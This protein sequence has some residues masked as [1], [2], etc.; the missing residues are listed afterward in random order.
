MKLRRKQI[1]APGGKKFVIRQS[2]WFAPYVRKPG[3][4]RLTATLPFITRSNCGVYI[5]RSKRTKK[6]LYVG[7]S[8]KQ[9]QKTPP[10]IFRTGP[11]PNSI[12]PPILVSLIMK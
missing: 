9:L 5:I 10:A 11:A 8:A 4:K 6:I 1:K 2:R 3:Q 12:G 7:H